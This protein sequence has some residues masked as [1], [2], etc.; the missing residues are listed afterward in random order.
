MNYMPAPPSLSFD[1][2]STFASA[3]TQANVSCVQTSAGPIRFELSFFRSRQLELHFTALP[4]GCCVAVGSSAN[5]PSSYHIPLGE[6]LLLAMMGQPMGEAA[7]VSYAHG[8]EHA[9]RARSGARLAYVVPGEDLLHEASRSYIGRDAVAR[10]SKS[11]VSFADPARMGDLRTY[12]DDVFDLIC[13]APQAMQSPAVIRNIEQALM[14]RLLAADTSETMKGAAVGRM[15]VSRGAILRKVDELLRLETSEPIYVSEL[16]TATGV[17]QPTLFRIFYDVL[18]L[19]PKQYLQLRRLHLARNKLLH[20]GDPALS[21]SSVAFDC[22]FWQ[23]GRFGQAYRGL[24]GETP[25]QTLKRS[26]R[27]PAFR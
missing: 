3:L 25:S 8:S 5:V 17:S 11:K 1:D 4:V 16:C 22:G 27:L 15:P 26:R 23:L 12:L 18:G 7:L 24:F 19:S 6:T 9:I 10:K 2:A 14:E 13:K 21:V 20:D